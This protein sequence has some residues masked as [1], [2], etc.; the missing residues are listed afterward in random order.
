MNSTA[1]NS[2]LRQA[3]KAPIIMAFGDDEE[4]Q[5]SI[6]KDVFDDGK[7]ALKPD[8]LERIHVVTGQTPK[9][10][11]QNIQKEANSIHEKKGV[12]PNL[13]L[14]SDHQ[15]GSNGTSLDVID[16]VTDLKNEKLI[17]YSQTI[18]HSGSG[19]AITDF[20]EQKEIDI[21]T[22]EVTSSYLDAISVNASK[23]SDILFLRKS[24]TP[25]PIVETLEWADKLFTFRASEQNKP[26]Q[27][28]QA[29]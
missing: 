16:N 27:N 25:P 5:I 9:E 15:Y 12:R 19:D 24:G 10:L 7:S 18:I 22:E 26:E 1:L 14:W 2:S 8:L 28:N 3:T 21:A 6:K 13:L 11:A 4:V 20:K 23:P 29:A 17:G